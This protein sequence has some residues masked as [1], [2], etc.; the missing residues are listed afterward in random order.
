MIEASGFLLK[1]FCPICH[2]PLHSI[3]IDFGNPGTA[4]QYAGTCNEHGKVSPMKLIFQPKGRPD[5]PQSVAAA[6]TSEKE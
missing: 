4:T 6:G 2:R 3:G 1:A 5:P